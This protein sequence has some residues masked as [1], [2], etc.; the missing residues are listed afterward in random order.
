[1]ERLT[2]TH[3]A[4]PVAIFLLPAAFSLYY[5]ITRNLLPGVAAFGLFG[6]GLLLFTL[7][8]YAMHRGGYHLAPTTPARARFQ[9][10]MHGVHHSSLKDKTRFA[11]PPILTVFV[12][13]PLFFLF[14]FVLGHAAL[15]VLA[16]F[17]FGYAP[18]LLVHYS[19]HV[20]APSKNVLKRLWH[21]H[22]IHHYTQESAA[23]GVCTTLWNHV[24]GTVPR[25]RPR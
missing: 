19:L 2:H 3:F 17:V 18:Y 6:A 10:T 7:V 24:F 14:H 12:A 4:A 23:F 20:Y 22:A 11:M 21:H 9:Y 16:G 5:G 1:M 15:R 13:S 25:R 8:E